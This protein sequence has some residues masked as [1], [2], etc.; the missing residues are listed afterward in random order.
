MT[1]SWWKIPVYCM[2]AS[3]IC[4]Q[5]ETRFLGRWTVVTLPD[6]SITTDGTRWLIMTAVLF[7]AV[8]CIGGLLFFRKMTRRELFYSASALAALN[9]VMGVLL[10]LGLIPSISF[11]ILW[12]ELTEWDAVFSQIF[13]QLGLHGWASTV[14]CLLVPPYVFLL[15]GKKEGIAG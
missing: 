8:V 11:S 7:V 14:F 3:W 6:G 4:F 2:V 5:L 13:I 15:F 9:V 12:S 1:K 10:S